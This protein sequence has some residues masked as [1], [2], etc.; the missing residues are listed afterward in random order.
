MNVSLEKLEIGC[1]ILAANFLN[2]RNIISVE[3]PITYRCNLLCSYCSQK[4]YVKIVEQ[5]TDRELTLEQIK[6]AFDMLEKLKVKRVNISGGEPL[7]RED[8]E[9]ILENAFLRKFTT[10][11]T[12]NGILVPKYVEILRG[13]SVLV[14]SIDGEEE[15]HDLL[16]GREGHKLALKA[17]DL[18]C[19]KGIKV[20][21]SAVITKKTTKEDVAYLLKLC[22][23]YGISCLLSP[24]WDRLFVKDEWALCHKSEKLAPESEQIKELFNFLKTNKKRKKVI[25]SFE[26]F[27]LLID[28]Y[29]NK[30]SVKDKDRLKKCMAG[31]LFLYIS[32][33]GDIF[34]CSMRCEKLLDKKIHE[35]SFEEILKMRNNPI[36]CSGCHCYIYALLNNLSK[37]RIRSILHGLS[38]SN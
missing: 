14:I 13:L 18:A 33:D 34:P 30:K 8:I 36:K 5:A 37:M 12:T 22:D 20:V 21:L 17:I 25:N 38:I 31:K 32:V 7:I 27:N 4:I 26:H 23:F 6:N 16:R 28:L 35:C 9:K 29:N 15:N 3:F 11:L 2:L 19:N 1:R 10:T 24:I